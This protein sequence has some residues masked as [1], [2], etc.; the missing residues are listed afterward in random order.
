MNIIAIWK[1]PIVIYSLL[2]FLEDKRKV[3]EISYFCLY[4]FYDIYNISHYNREIF[5]FQSYIYI[6]IYI[7]RERERESGNLPRV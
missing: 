6:Y 1:S 5:G 3:I 7:E 2:L 4:K